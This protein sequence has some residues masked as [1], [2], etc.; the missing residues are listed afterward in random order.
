VNFRS[1]AVLIAA[2]VALAWPAH[3]QPQFGGGVQAS[4]TATLNLRTGPGVRH[5][6]IMRIP[7]GQ[8]V[9]LFGCNRAVSWCHVSYAGRQGWVSARYL[10][11]RPGAGMPV[12]PAPW[13]Q[14][15][16]PT[17]PPPSQPPGFPMPTLPPGGTTFIG[18]LT[19]EGVECPAM[20]GDDGRLYTLAGNIGPFRPGDRVQVLGR[21]AQVSFCMQG[22]TIEVQAIGPAT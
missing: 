21:P 10:S 2:I 3:A 5:A 4:V 22:T 20:R 18:T 15:I 1:F 9:R 11:P 7:R 14:P 19:G 6:V 13:P 17:F 8:W 12:P 16:P